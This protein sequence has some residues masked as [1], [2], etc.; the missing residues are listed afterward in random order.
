MKGRAILTTTASDS[1]SWN[2]VFMQLFLE[3]RGYRVR[4]L[5]VCVPLDL[6][7]RECRRDQPDLVVVSTLNGHGYL[8]GARIA[9]RLAELDERQGMALVIGGALATDRGLA[10]R[11]ASALRQAG[12]DAVFSGSRSLAELSD[13]LK[14]LEP[15]PV[16]PS[17]AVLAAGHA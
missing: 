1:H 12:F 8:E 4:N 13:F 7:V 10:E 14:R 16:T 9:L 3:E 6:L 15:R 5:G 2:L 17:G 11:C